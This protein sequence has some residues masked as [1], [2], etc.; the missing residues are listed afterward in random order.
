MMAA[1]ASGVAYEM[2]LKRLAAVKQG[3]GNQFQRENE[4]VKERIKLQ[5]ELNAA[6]DDHERKQKQRAADNEQLGIQRLA[7]QKKLAEAEAKAAKAEVDR[8]GPEAAKAAEKERLGAGRI[9]EIRDAEKTA[10]ENLVKNE[11]KVRELTT[12]ISGREMA[13]DERDQIMA[14]AAKGDIEG[15]KR[16]SPMTYGKANQLVLLA[17]GIEGAKTTISATPGLL[18]TA[19]ASQFGRVIQ[20][21]EAA[22]ALGAAQGKATTATSLAQGLGVQL[23]VAGDESAVRRLPGFMQRRTDT[24]F[25]AAEGAGA[26]RQ[27]I[28]A[29]DDQKK[30]IGAMAQALGL[31]GRN[32]QE[33]LA[34]LDRMNDDQ[35]Q[36]SAALAALRRTP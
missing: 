18:R 1:A 26:I 23:G 6:E 13:P 8:L 12:G 16:I 14:L 28:G 9:S 22:D 34:I 4:A 2:S 36:F 27:G 35:A 29:T 7:R 32:S 15:M 20:S 3:L 10:R 25:S 17:Q 24:I 19:E 5:E 21:K 11:E 33:V 30:A 31:V